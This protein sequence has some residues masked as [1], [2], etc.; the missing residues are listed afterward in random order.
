MF[1]FG[2]NNN[3]PSPPQPPD[4]GLEITVMPQPEDARRGAIPEQPEPPPR[5]SAPIAEESSPADQSASRGKS[6]GRQILNLILIVLIVAGLVYLAYLLYQ[7]KVAKNAPTSQGTPNIVISPQQPDQKVDTDHDGLTDQQEQTLG[8]DPN[9]PDTDGDGL[10]DGDEVNIYHS[11]PLLPDT[12]HEGHSDGTDIIN[13]YSPLT[14]KKI[15]AEEQQQW[16]QRIAQFGLHEPT[17]T[18]L[19]LQAAK[20]AAVTASINYT[21]AKFKYQFVIPAPLT[22]REGPGAGQLGIYVATSAT[23]TDTGIGT[24]PIV[25]ETG[26]LAGN[27]QLADFVASQYA[28]GSFAKEAGI[29]VKGL[30]GIKLT[31]VKNDACPQDKTFFADP[32]GSVVVLTLTCDTS[33]PFVPFYESIVQSFKFLL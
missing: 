27:Q 22:F 1:N 15:S 6:R 18:T 26:G 19:K 29:N 8:T 30:P 28:A 5:A 20:A 7:Q 12:D 21:N 14:G 9:N 25:V 32:R 24:D 17:L 10:A 23:S 31:G 33:T 3:P 2:K 4:D 16:S 13:G 11:D